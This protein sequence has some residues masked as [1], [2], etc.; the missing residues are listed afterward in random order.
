MV[1]VLR[2]LFRLVYHHALLSTPSAPLARVSSASG[3][4][5]STVTKKATVLC[6]G[7][8][9]LTRASLRAP[10][11]RR[12]AAGAASKRGPGGRLAARA[13]AA[14]VTEELE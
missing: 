3:Q 2:G 11:P 14:P 9:C 10:P 4:P 5:Q 12:R 8:H 6:H 13:L 1:I 7:S